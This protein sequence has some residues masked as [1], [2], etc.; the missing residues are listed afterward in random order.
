MNKMIDLCGIGNGLVDLQFKVSFEELEK[1]GDRK[2]EMCLVEPDEQKKIIDTLIQHKHNKCSGGSAAN[3]I[4]AFAKFGGRAAYKTVLGNDD[5]GK[6]YKQEFDSLG[7]E[8]VAPLLDEHPTGTCLVLITPDSERTM[9][10][11]LGATGYFNSD[12][13]DYDVIAK[14]KWIYLE[15]YKFTSPTSTDALYDAVNIAHKYKT[16]IALT[17]SDVFIVNSFYDK[18]FGIV[19]QSDLIF[20]NEPEANAF[21]QKDNIEDSFNYLCEIC[22]NVVVTMNDKG[23]DRKSVV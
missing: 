5:F 4:I 20:C 2:G 1:I 21:A 18:L 6:F 7:I 16:K 10:T 13:L 15:G 12:L 19:K 14:S 23:S 22:P 8:L 17:F 3:T 11:A 9:K